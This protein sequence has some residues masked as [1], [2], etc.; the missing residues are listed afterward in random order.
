[1][2]GQEGEKID[3]LIFNVPLW[4]KVG[5]ACDQVSQFLYQLVIKKLFEI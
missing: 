1:M 5:K 3:V 2:K 4:S